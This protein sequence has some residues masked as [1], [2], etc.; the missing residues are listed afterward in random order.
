[1]TLDGY[2]WQHVIV[3]QNVWHHVLLAFLSLPNG[4]VFIS[5]YTDLKLDV[6]SVIFQSLYGWKDDMSFGEYDL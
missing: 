6:D 5:M 3:C 2:A 4:V 1:M